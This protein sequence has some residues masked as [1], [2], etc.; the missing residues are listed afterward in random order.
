M[1]QARPCFRSQIVIASM[2]YLSIPQLGL[3]KHLYTDLADS[4]TD[5]HEFTYALHVLSQWRA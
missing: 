3:A 4:Q 1:W 2:A 5:H